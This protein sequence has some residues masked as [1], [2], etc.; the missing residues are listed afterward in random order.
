MSISNLSLSFL[1]SFENVNI[2]F[3]YIVQMQ[4]QMKFQMKAHSLS[5]CHSQM[6]DFVAY[7]NLFCPVFSHKT[8]QSQI[9]AKLSYYYLFYYYIILNLLFFNHVETS[10]WKLASADKL[11]KQLN[12]Y[13]SIYSG[14][15]GLRS[16]RIV[17][18]SWSFHYL[19]LSP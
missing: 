19:S 10:W 18:I 9:C 1:H 16:L 6:S 8:I 17:V 11:Q 4:F 13:L 12:C 7:F 3:S 15:S 14:Q 5:L 2:T